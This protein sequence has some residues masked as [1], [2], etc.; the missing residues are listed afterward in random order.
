MADSTEPTAAAAVAAAAVLAELE[1]LSNPKIPN[2]VV[3]SKYMKKFHLLYKMD[4][5][6]LD[7]DKKNSNNV[8]HVC[9]FCNICFNLT[10]RMLGVDGKGTYDT[11]K[12]RCH[13]K[14]ECTGGGKYCPGILD[15]V[16]K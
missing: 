9:S 12:V 2:G 5:R 14:L 4:V 11:T 7:I 8:S 3:R 15:L 13:L 16:K 6:R 1:A 10:W